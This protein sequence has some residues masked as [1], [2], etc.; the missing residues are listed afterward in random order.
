MGFQN[1]ELRGGVWKKVNI[2]RSIH[3]LNKP[4]ELEGLEGIA[5]RGFWLYDYISSEKIFRAMRISKMGNFQLR[6]QIIGNSW[7]QG[8]L[9]GSI[10][11]EK[12]PS[13]H[14]CDHNDRSTGRATFPFAFAN[15]ICFKEHLQ[16]KQWGMR[17]RRKVFRRPRE[18]SSRFEKLSFWAL[19]KGP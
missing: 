9:W 15:Y 12:S 3:F 7:F 10:K 18:P 13:Q 5:P 14:V 8:G 16:H 19:S 4:F 11:S 6:H 17:M 1:R 2:S